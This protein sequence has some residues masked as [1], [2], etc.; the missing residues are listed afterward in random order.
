MVTQIDSFEFRFDCVLYDSQLVSPLYS[1][2]LAL[3]CINPQQQFLENEFKIVAE[4]SSIFF[5]LKSVFNKTWLQPTLACQCLFWLKS[6]RSCLK[7]ELMLPSTAF[8]LWSKC[9]RFLSLLSSCVKTNLK[10]EELP[11][12]CLSADLLLILTHWCDLSAPFLMN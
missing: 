12:N 2:M 11:P 9:K 1:N 6:P 8:I 5:F 3:S 7:Q 4:N 10:W